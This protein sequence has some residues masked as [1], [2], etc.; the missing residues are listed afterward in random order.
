M[1]PYSPNLG[2]KDKTYRVKEINSELLNFYPTDENLHQGTVMDLYDSEGNIGTA[3]TVSSNTA[4]IVTESSGSGWVKAKVSSISMWFDKT[5]DAQLLSEAPLSEVEE[6]GNLEIYFNTLYDSK[7]LRIQWQLEYEDD[8]VAEGWHPAQ[9]GRFFKFSISRWWKEG[10]Y[11]LTAQSYNPQI[12]KVLEQR[13][14]NWT[15]DVPQQLIGCGQTWNIIPPLE[16]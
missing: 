14:I 8:V 12:H 4:L 11:Q 10:L 1:E 16:L 7:N 2:N 5:G 13:V 9:R 15:L 3:I 6:P